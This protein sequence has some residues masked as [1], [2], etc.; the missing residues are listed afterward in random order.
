VPLVRPF[1]MTFVQVEPSV[2]S[3]RSKRSRRLLPF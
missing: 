1:V 2:E 3:C